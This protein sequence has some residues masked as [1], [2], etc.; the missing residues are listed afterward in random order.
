MF[1]PLQTNKGLDINSLIKI[2]KNK[3]IYIWGTGQ[4][5][6]A[7]KRMLEKN[8]IEVSGFCDSNKNMSNK[9]IDNSKVYFIEDIIKKVQKKRLF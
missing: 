2:V 6:R 4:L 7:L 8:N 9:I 3:D 1:K 5:G